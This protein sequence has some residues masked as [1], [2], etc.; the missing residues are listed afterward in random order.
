MKTRILA[1]QD[2]AL[3]IGKFGMLTIL[4]GMLT[5]PMPEIATTSWP[6]A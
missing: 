5:F 6:L 3:H 1:I 2:H 4:V